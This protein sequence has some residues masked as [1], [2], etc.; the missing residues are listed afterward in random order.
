MKLL[1]PFVLFL[2]LASGP[3]SAAPLEFNRDVRPILSDKCFGCHGPDSGHRKA[4]LRLDLRDAA[5]KPAKSGDVP[6]SPGNPDGSQ[7]L[8]RICSTDKE[9][10]MPPPEAKLEPLSKAE[11]ETLRRWVSEG[12]EY[13]PLWS[14]IPPKQDKQPVDPLSIRIDGLIQKR[15]KDRGITQR[16]EATPDRLLRRVTLDLTGLPPSPADVRA[17]L[18]DNQP[19]AYERAVDRLLKSSS[20]GERWASDWL[21]VSRYADSYG[22]QVD[23]DRSVWPWRD[24][25]VNALNRNLPFNDFVTWQLAG[26]LLPSPTEEQILATSFNR[27]HQQEAEGGSVEEEYRVEYVADRVQTFATAFLGLTFECAKCHDHKFDPISQKEFYQMFAFFDDIDEA[28]LYSFFTGDAPTPAIRLLSPDTQTKLEELQR[29]VVQAETALKEADTQ[30]R[31]GFD[32]WLKQRTEAFAIPNE[33]GRF[34]SAKIGDNKL[35]NLIDSKKTASLSGENKSVE[36]RSEGTAAIQLSGD[37]ELTL[38]VGSFNRSDPF[39]VS[40]W[41]QTPDPKERAVILHRSKAWTDA[42][43]RGFELLL[44]DGRLKWSLVRFWPGDAASIRTTTQLVPGRWTHVAITSDGSGKASG[45]RI[46]INGNAAQTEVIK[47]NLSRDITPGRE[48]ITLGARMRDRGFKN[49]LLDDLRIFERELSAME[50]AA[51][52]SP[53]EANLLWTKA[54][55]Q[56]SPL[57]KTRLFETFLLATPP[58][59]RREALHDLRDA[60]IAVLKLLESQPEMSVMKDLP[61]PKKAF[62]LFRG[63][64]DQRRD[65]VFADTPASLPKFPADSPRNRLGLARWLTS[66]DHPLLARVTVNRFWQSIFGRG[67]VRTSDDFGSQGTPPEYQG[68][69]DALATEFIRSG[70]DVK[71][72]LKGIVMSQTYKQDSLGSPELTADDPENVLLARG[73]RFRLP[74]EAVRDTFLSASGLLSRKMG[75]APVNPYESTEAFR[76][77]PADKGEGSLRRSLYTRWRRTSPPPAMMAFDSARRAVCSAKRERTNTPLQ[78]LVLL[79]GTQYVEAARV[80]GERLH[81]AYADNLESMIEEAFLACLS[82]FPDAK[83]KTILT[84]L[85]NEQLNHFKAHQ[86]DA[87]ALLNVGQAPVDRALPVAEVAAATILAQAL[88]NHDGSVV[89]Q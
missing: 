33:I 2:G 43:S 16:Q 83:E 67:L 49:G 28:G 12:A 61:K 53:S 73:S 66:P 85:Y 78:A 35:T 62:V 57:E 80:L 32:S 75:G 8:T 70:W 27:L 22:F 45:L 39:T 40:L 89:K 63:Q 71:A 13:Q 26:D 25:V 87:K 60:R 59:A 4:G 50:I 5:I 46:F 24:W 54:S 77:I 18:A 37:D 17:Y 23:R 88:L 51:T 30:A 11:I 1:T 65:E 55:E 76:P 29:V 20:Y 72:L 41:I 52:F 34:H 74:A 10:V 56:L 64:Y 48:N 38:P 86:A 21:D 14:F 82:R 47:D 79:N 36:G 68:V 19:G 31:T 84:K 3:L 42:A 9:E 58:D 15:L 6:L 44:E 7:I 81:K 69:L